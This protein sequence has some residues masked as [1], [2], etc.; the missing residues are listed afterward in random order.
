MGSDEEGG[1]GDGPSGLDIREDYRPE[2]ASQEPQLPSVA[3][4]D[5]QSGA[6]VSAENVQEHMRI[7]L[8]DPKW[9][10]Q[11]ER[12]REKH[13]QTNFVKGDS[14]SKN[15]KRFAKRRPDIFEAENGSGNTE[16]VTPLPKQPEQTRTM[17]LVSDTAPQLSGAPPLPPDT[18]AAPSRLPARQSL[19]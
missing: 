19:L 7:Q 11:R 16:D 8:L 18:T 9:H 17:P 15:L 3:M 4:V 10:E 5:P 12:H 6:V 14:I 2:M 1:V 13:K